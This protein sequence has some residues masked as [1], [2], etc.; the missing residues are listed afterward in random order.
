[1]AHQ[2]NAAGFRL[3]KTFLWNNTE[4]INPTNKSTQLIKNANTSQG[5]DNTLNYILQRQNMFVVKSSLSKNSVDSVNLNVLYYPLTSPMLRNRT[6]PLY[7]APRSLL[8]KSHKYNSQFKTLVSKV[9]SF[10]TREFNN[11]F[12][13]AK[14]KK[15]LNSMITK[16]LFIGTKSFYGSKKR[17]GL[18]SWFKTKTFLKH[19]NLNYRNNKNKLNRWH[20]SKKLINTYKLSKQL[21]KRTGMRVQVKLQNAFAYVLKKSKKLSFKK[22]QRHL[23]NKRYHFN[24]KRFMSYY[25]IVNSFYLLSNIN[26][27]E[28][29]VL[30]MIQ[31]GLTNM[32]RRKIRPKNMF[33]FL[34]SI[35][36]NMKAIQKNFNAFRLIITGKLRGGTSRTQAFSTG[37]GVF[38]KQTLDKNISYVFGDV[39]SKY[40]AFGVKIFT[41]RKSIHETTTDA[42]VKWALLQQR[43]SKKY[44]NTKI[45]KV[46]KG[47]KKKVFNVLRAKFNTLLKPIKN[48]S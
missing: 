17:F 30:K 12:V 27:A 38:P 5:L 6:F 11:R 23:W 36:K 40:G 13:R 35:V 26:G 43:R 28:Q 24:K 8:S 16:A 31:Y 20:L 33:Y 44:A 15:N 32:H 19:N 42:Q 25:D 41:W 48:K 45:S 22:H 14:I 7:A 47:F 29:L 46:K 39:R 9:W 10:K 1:M 18:I 21:S 4:I 3:G 37:F 34:N 2:V